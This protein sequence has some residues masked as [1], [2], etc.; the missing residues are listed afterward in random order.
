MTFSTVSYINKL[1]DDVPQSA[2]EELH[3]E[4]VNKPTNIPFL[5][6]YVFIK[7]FERARQGLCYDLRGNTPLRIVIKYGMNVLL[8]KVE[9]RIKYIRVF[10]FLPFW[11]FCNFILQ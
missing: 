11:Q 1:G 9:R 4:S 8:N 2:G 5:R 6:S 7:I 10:I 3:Q